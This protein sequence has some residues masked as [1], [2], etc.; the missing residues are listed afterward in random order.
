MEIYL[1]HKHRVHYDVVT[2]VNDLPSQVS[3]VQDEQGHSCKTFDACSE[4]T[5]HN[6]HKQSERCE[7]QVIDKLIMTYTTGRKESVKRC[8]P[9]KRKRQSVGKRRQLIKE[10][11]R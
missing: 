9:K 1:N 3:D 2:S 10:R 5:E 11:I 8:I 4:Y 6:D 7:K